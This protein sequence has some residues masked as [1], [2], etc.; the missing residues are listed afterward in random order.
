MENGKAHSLP[1]KY[2]LGLKGNQFR[3]DTGGKVQEL[4]VTQ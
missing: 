2:K 1:H 3:F 4:T